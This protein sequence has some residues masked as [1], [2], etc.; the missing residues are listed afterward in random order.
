MKSKKIF[1]VAVLALFISASV[2]ISKQPTQR[3]RGSQESRQLGPQTTSL[4]GK[5]TD[6]GTGLTVLTV[7]VRPLSIHIGINAQ[8]TFSL[9]GAV[10]NLAGIQIGDSVVVNYPILRSEAVN[11]NSVEAHRHR[12]GTVG[13]VLE[14]PPPSA[15]YPYCP[16]V[17]S[18]GT[19]G[20]QYTPCYCKACGGAGSGMIW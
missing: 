9:N 4:N 16:Y 20:N 14:P 3:E 10:T 18:G 1:Q 7:G 15:G 5:V 19:V 12:R 6:K 8:T 11:A 2:A 17:G 13:D